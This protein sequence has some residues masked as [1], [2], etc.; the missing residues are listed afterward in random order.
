MNLHRTA[1]RLPQAVE[2]SRRLLAL[3]ER[4]GDLRPTNLERLRLAWLL[5]D[6]DRVAEAGRFVDVVM[7]A[8]DSLSRDLAYPLLA[9]VALALGDYL[10]A[11][12]AADAAI[13]TTREPAQ[14]PFMLETRAR[15]GEKLGDGAGALADIDAALALVEE[16]RGGLVPSD[17][18][19]QGH[20]E[21]LQR[22]FGYAIALHMRFDQAEAA[23]QAAEQ[24]RA[25]AFVD[26]LAAREGAL[27]SAAG[28]G[29]IRS[30]TS[31]PPA[32]VDRLADVAKRLGSVI[33]SYWVAP[34]RT[35]IWVVDE[36]GRVSSASV[37]LDA[38]QLA[39]SIRR[40]SEEI[41]LSGRPS[42]EERRKLYDAL[43]RPVRRFLPDAADSLLTIV[44][45]GPLFRLS[46][47]S[48]LDE[49]QAY[50]I[51]RYRLHYAPSVDALSYLPDPRTPPDGVDHRSQG[52]DQ[53]RIRYL[54]VADPA[55]RPAGGQGAPPP[56]PD[57]LRE[58][59]AIANTLPP[60]AGTILTGVQATES[61]VRALLTGQ[62]VVHLATHGQLS[63]DARAES[64]FVL[65][66]GGSAQADDGR[67]TTA[68]IYELQLDADLVVLS[69]CR[70]ARGA[71]TG[72][73]VLGMTR[74]F[75]YAGAPSIVATLWDVADR[76]G[77]ELLP[78]FYRSWHDGASKSRALRDAQLEMIGRLRRGQVMVSTP[79]GSRPLPEHP[80]LWASFVLVGEP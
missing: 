74:A 24:A 2:A 17:L 46:F 23:L 25:R 79:G 57:A 44:P 73:G 20:A 22:L 11:R 45:H 16:A 68:E 60:G 61:R 66:G 72:D 76:A 80:F 12:E 42:T 31:A 39:S 9:N 19:K 52:A 13:R 1:G 7:Q 29:E 34:A 36:T 48:L 32:S 69:A 33:V 35:F 55:A 6:V 3:H 47:A 64:F 77:A 15:A 26:L 8:G 21:R 28:A 14:I 62:R 30:M 37:A 59:R 27:A 38:R 54:F 75:M 71:I 10:R 4:T 78:A 5:L 63:D 51:E 67:L 41:D 58:V 70:S 56:L 43:I 18:M 65:S 40:M 49:R 50:L 53:G